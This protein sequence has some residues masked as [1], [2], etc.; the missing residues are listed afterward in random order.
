MMSESGSSKL[1]KA[2]STVAL[3]WSTL[4]TV[5]KAFVPR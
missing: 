2:C 3:S 4:L 1:L 5:F